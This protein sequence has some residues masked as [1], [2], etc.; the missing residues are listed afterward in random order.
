MKSGFFLV[1]VVLSTLLSLSVVVISLVCMVVLA[2]TEKLRKKP[3]SVFVMN[4]LIT[5]LVQ[6]LIV[7]PAYAIRKSYIL[8]EGYYYSL[9]CDVWRLGYMLTFYGTCINVML[10]AIDRLIF[11]QFALSKRIKLERRTCVKICSISWIY[12]GLLCL[13]PFLPIRRSFALK[14][15]K[16]SYNQPAEWSVFMLIGNCAIPFL[17]ISVCYSRIIAINRKRFNSI[18]T[19]ITRRTSD[20]SIRMQE[21]LNK[22]TIR[23]TLLYAITWLPSIIYYSIITIRTNTFSKEF[24]TSSLES[25]IVFVNKFVT[26]FDAVFA[27]LVYCYHSTEFKD[28]FRQL[29][30]VRR[31]NTANSTT[32]GFM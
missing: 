14:G 29:F 9:G 23:I 30:R 28:A 12:I 17:V 8:P 16:C 11:V 4:L 32:V 27:P 26:F 6:G 25:V 31:T 24:Y 10:V 20:R 2:C 22:L 15:S 3:S 19:Q 18:Q 7:L 5:H 13:V 1:A 21:K